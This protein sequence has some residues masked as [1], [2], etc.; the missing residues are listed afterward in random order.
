VC[1]FTAQ[2]LRLCRIVPYIGIFELAVYFFEPVLVASIVKDT[3]STL[4]SAAAGPGVDY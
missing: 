1:T 2:R 4:Q 3:P